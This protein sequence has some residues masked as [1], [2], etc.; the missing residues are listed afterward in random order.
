[1]PM[2]GLGVFGMA[3]DGE[4][5]ACVQAAIEVGYRSVDTATIYGSEAGVGRAL[6]KCGVPRQ[7]LFVTTKVW[8]D[9]VRQGRVRAAFE[10]SLARLGLDYIDLYLVH[11]PIPKHSV[12]TWKVLERLH[13][14]GRVRA[15]GVS[16]H[17]ISDLEAIMACAEIPPAVNQIEFHPYLQSRALLERC[18]ELGICVQAW[19]PLMRAG[20]ILADPDLAAIAERHR[21]T[22]PQ[23]ILRWHYQRNVATVPKAA[24]QRH[25]IE[26]RQ[27]FDFVLAAADMA[28]IDAMDRGERSGP[29]P[30]TFDF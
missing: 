2:Q 15:I 6:R 30:R 25:M 12:A 11:W 21:R 27:V 13:A 19:S 7:E 24:R 23:V 9:D 17:M 16:N 18:R 4:V 26:N 10:A 14:E 3:R 5:E 29:D 8:T 28:T 22:V 20:S 1:M